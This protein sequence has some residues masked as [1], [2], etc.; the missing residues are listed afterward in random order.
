[1]IWFLFSDV[2][3][4][5]RSSR[6]GS[7]SPSF[8]Q[9]SSPGQRAK[10]KRNFI[11]NIKP[12]TFKRPSSY[13][14]SEAEI[15][16]AKNN[17]VVELVGYRKMVAS[18][19][20]HSKVLGNSKFVELGTLSPLRSSTDTKSE[21]PVPDSFLATSVSMP[22]LLNRSGWA[23]NSDGTLPEYRE[24]ARRSLRAKKKHAKSSVISVDFG[25]S[26]PALRSEK[27]EKTD[28]TDGRRRLKR[29]YTDPVDHS[30]KSAL[31]SNENDNESKLEK[32]DVSSIKVESSSLSRVSNNENTTKSSLEAG[33][34]G[35]EGED[36]TTAKKGLNF[37]QELY[38]NLSKCLTEALG[39]GGGLNDSDK[40]DDDECIQNGFD[41][42]L[43]SSISPS[44]TDD[45][46]QIEKLDKKLGTNHNRNSAIKGENIE[47]V[48]DKDLVN[49]E[50]VSTSAPKSGLTVKDILKNSDLKIGVS[51][52]RTEA[53]S[54]QST[55][56]DSGVDVL[57]VSG[58]SVR[59]DPADSYA[60]LKESTP[61]HTSRESKEIVSEVK[62]VCDTE[63]VSR[64][65]RV[66]VSEFL[67]EEYRKSSN[68]ELSR[69]LENLGFQ[70][71]PQTTGLDSDS[72][73]TEISSVPA[74]MRNNFRASS[75]SNLVHSGSGLLEVKK[76]GDVMV[77][78]ASFPELSKIADIIKEP[79]KLVD[80]VGHN[81][82][83]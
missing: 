52:E 74:S 33:K 57:S 27:C 40:S 21:S 65:E 30:S 46:D 55:N 13:S 76:G 80:K 16:S 6:S 34:Q 3:D 22:T 83:K 17:K 29:A 59:D 68:L 23:R 25:G 78:S 39:D 79:P 19:D 77:S 54:R 64:K 4:N 12:D 67:R 70:D 18:P 82:V 47:M 24:V 81:T 50:K 53:L 72:G 58:I 20:L 32:D 45:K 36:S 2:S 1:M 31:S 15:A 63:R 56:T 60:T 62:I 61:E 66:T 8:S 10:S 41:E 44:R 73:I 69:N 7:L 28:H 26:D 9:S 42:L 49:L 38:Q 51:S 48:Q 71:S 75:E 14:C 11:K 37:Q 43:E 35:K 5:A